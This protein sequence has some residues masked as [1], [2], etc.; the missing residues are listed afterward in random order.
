MG[1]KC[2]TLNYTV[3]R[4]QLWQQN[5]FFWMKEETWWI[6]WTE[7]YHFGWRN[8]R[9]WEVQISARCH[10]SIVLIFALTIILHCLEPPAHQSDSHTTWYFWES[11]DLWWVGIKGPRSANFAG[12]PAYP[13]TVANDPLKDDF[14]LNGLGFPA[15]HVWLLGG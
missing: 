2:E 12:S 11:F 8:G 9:R 13:K 3:S 4:C 5:S 1:E 14:P 15:G 10:H 6:E 7:G